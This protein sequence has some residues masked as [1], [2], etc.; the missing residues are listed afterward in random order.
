MR[1]K[2]SSFDMSGGLG[3]K[4]ELELE[5]ELEREL[6]RELLVRGT[7]VNYYFVC[8]TKLWLF[9]HGIQMEQ[10]SD[11][12]ALG[13][14]LHRYSYEDVEKDVIIDDLIAIDFVRSGETLEIHEV[15]KSDRMEKAH[16]MQTL[17]YLYFL[18]RRK[19]IEKV[20]AVITYPKLRKRKELLLD[21]RAERE[22]EEV[23][24]GIERVVRGEMPKPERKPIC[25]RCA[26]YELCFSA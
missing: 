13:Y 7:Q 15:K 12:V 17:Y 3:S 6:R 8:R 22:L 14:L 16:E 4:P 26:Y 2:I 18:K 5:P 23:L 11:L 1:T 10:E 21:E 25:R 20:K 9:S 19:G 24:D